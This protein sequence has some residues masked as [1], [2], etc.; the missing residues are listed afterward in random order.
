M[1]YAQNLT[2]ED[3]KKLIP[4]REPILLIDEV[5]GWEA[6]KSIN[7]TRYF[8]ENDPLFEGHF[9]GDP[10]LPGMLTVEAIAQAAATLTSLSEK[11]DVTNAYYVFTG[12]E[13]VRLSKPV[14]PGETI[15][16]HAEKV[17]DRL[18]IYVFKGTAHVNGN[19]VAK[20]TFT[21]KLMRR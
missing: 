17:R 21:A 4:H 3:I 7:A 11:V 18:G 12:I 1:D 2:R 14:R 9:P 13:D 19:L 15:T 16:L 5:I 20:A 6:H 8:P 10:Y